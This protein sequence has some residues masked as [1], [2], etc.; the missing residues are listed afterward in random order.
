MYATLLDFGSTYTKVVCVNLDD[1]RIAVSDK[2]PSTVHEDAEIALD[3]CLH[4]AQ[5]AIGCAAV[6][7]SLKLASSSAAGGL[8]IAVSGLTQSLSSQAGRSAC[9]GAGGKIVCSCAGIL[10]QDDIDSIVDSGAEIILFCGGYDNGNRQAVLRNAR[11]LCESPVTIPVIYSG[12]SALVSEIRMLFESHGKECFITE[13]I[14]PNVGKLNIGPTVEVIRNIFMNRI[15]NMMGV[16]GV[17]QRMDGPITPTPAAVLKAGELL[18][19][20]TEQEPGIG[21]YMM[22]DIGGATTDIYSFAENIA[23]DGART[24]GLPEPVCKRTVEGDMGMRES[25]A[26][27]AAETG[28]SRIAETCG[29]TEEEVQKAV[30]HRMEH[31]DYVADTPAERQFDLCL[32]ANAVRISAERHAGRIQRE[33]DHGTRLVQYGKNLTDVQTVIGTGGILVNSAASDSRHILEQIRRT[34]EDRLLPDQIGT[35]VDRNY[36]FYAAGLIAD[37]YPDCAVAMMK[38]SAGLQK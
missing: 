31:H 1:G 24:A 2:V 14:I 4:I 25:S 12:N 32:A 10:K 28:A 29:I 34:S 35:H 18:Y 37:R 33:L 9:F 30:E 11:T 3:Q 15:T 5:R 8:R 13:N 38:N 22:V 23:Y 27:L 16:S 19:R 20:G 17:Q 26:S 36:V 6:A 21:P 7:E